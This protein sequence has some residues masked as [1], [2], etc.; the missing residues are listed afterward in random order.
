M[1]EIYQALIQSF[2][3]GGFDVDIAYEN[4]DYTPTH[5]TAYVELRNIA[6]DI[7]P[8]TINETDFIDGLFR[9]TLYS[10]QNTGAI[11]ARSIIDEI[12][13]YYAIGRRFQYQDGAYVEV[14]GK[15]IDNPINEG[16]WYKTVL[17]VAYKS[18]ITRE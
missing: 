11:S 2:I 9:I 3:D 13:K 4:A 8:L 16:G 18:L 10:T 5:G 1:L 17:T 12:C 14:S 15:T 7:R 6:N